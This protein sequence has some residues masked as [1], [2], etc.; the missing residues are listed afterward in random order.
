[1]V[2]ASDPS[3]RNA[4]QT[5]PPNAAQPE[6]TSVGPHLAALFDTALR[7]RQL[8]V[9]RMARAATASFKLILDEFGHSSAIFQAA[10]ECARA[11]SEF[12]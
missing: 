9:F 11:E 6:D 3:S 2:K 12:T 10:Q 8:G 7:E 4:K 1:M 5:K